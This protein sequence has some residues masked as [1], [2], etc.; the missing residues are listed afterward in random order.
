[1]TIRRRPTPE[2]LNQ[3]IEARDSEQRG[4]GAALL[5]EVY[6]FLGRFVAYPSEAAHVAHTLWVGHTFFMDCWDSTPR[7]AFL[8]PEPGSGK[9]RALEVTEPL[10][11]RPV[12]AVNVSPSYLFRKVSDDEGLPVILYDEIDTIFGPRA[13][14][15]EDIRGLLNAGHRRGAI[16]GR[17]VTKGKTIVTEDFP[18]YA[19]VA[20]AGLDDL[21]D[22]LQ[23]RSVIVRM[24]RRAP[25]EKVEP[26]RNRLNTPEG[27]AL[28]ERLETWAK[29][30]TSQVQWPEMP[31]GVEDRDADIWEALL[32]VADLAGGEW[33]KRAR[34]TAVTL[35]T[36]SKRGVPSLGIRLLGDIRQAFGALETLRTDDLVKALNKLDDAPWAEIKNGHPLD[37]RELARRLRK[38]DIHNKPVRIGGVVVRGYTAE[39]FWDA[40][41]RYLVKDVADPTNEASPINTGE[42]IRE[43]EGSGEVVE[44]LGPSPK[45]SVTSV[46]PVTN[47]TAPTCQW[48][49]C[50]RELTHPIRSNEAC[51]SRAGWQRA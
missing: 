13:K 39:S 49:G 7:I 11:N 26:W 15:N 41:T 2:E 31:D 35:V 51:A 6:D 32:V 50:G 23:S 40:W 48:Q 38:Y 46:T 4:K 9:S 21:P 42:V 25:N 16:A 18:A 28:R 14:D 37:S 45:G 33:P 10:V 27:E 5:T 29:V 44:A 47:T 36:D 22:T 24:R 1:M 30:S 43:E 20:L 12:H 17:C 19:A 8:S 3:A 34:V